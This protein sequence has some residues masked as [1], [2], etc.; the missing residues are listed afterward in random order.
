MA[1]DQ[2]LHQI[3]PASELRRGMAF[4]V[5]FGQEG[6]KFHHQRA[7]DAGFTL[8]AALKVARLVTFKPG[9]KMPIIFSKEA[10]KKMKEDMSTCTAYASEMALLA[11]VYDSVIVNGYNAEAFASIRPLW[12]E[13]QV[14]DLRCF[15]KLK[16]MKNLVRLSVIKPS[17]DFWGACPFMPANLVCLHLEAIRSEMSLSSLAECPALKELTLIEIDH[18]IGTLPMRLDRVT[19]GNVSELSARNVADL[20]THANDIVIECFSV[21][22][23]LPTFSRHLIRLHVP[24]W[25]IDHTDIPLGVDHLGCACYKDSDTT[26]MRVWNFNAPLPVELSVGVHGPKQVKTIVVDSRVIDLVGKD[27][28]IFKPFNCASIHSSLLCVPFQTRVQF[29]TPKMVTSGHAYF[30]TSD[31]MAL[32]LSCNFAQNMCKMMST[33]NVMPFVDKDMFKFLRLTANSGL[34]LPQEIASMIANKVKP[35][36]K[37]FETFTDKFRS[38]SESHS[39]TTM[40]EYCKLRHIMSMHTPDTCRELVETLMNYTHHLM[41]WRYVRFT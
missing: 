13:L 19:I 8:E 10:C 33:L 1:V 25:T 20:C 16:T 7:A 11:N 23:T 17:K 9:A 32:E 5:T 39:F 12:K 2:T 27:M 15:L 40:L 3:H 24:F 37:E 36:E 22:K 41:G 21:L 18:K 38:L 31:I 28:Q 35:T 29:V 26:I 30:L 6:V 34:H 14:Q 4:R